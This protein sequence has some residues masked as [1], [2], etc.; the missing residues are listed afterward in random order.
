MGI[1]GQ[2]RLVWVG[3]HHSSRDVL[4]CVMGRQLASNILVASVSGLILPRK[5]TENSRFYVVEEQAVLNSPTSSN[6]LLL[7]TPR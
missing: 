4:Q 5:L 6:S 2:T 3:S 1:D 7:I